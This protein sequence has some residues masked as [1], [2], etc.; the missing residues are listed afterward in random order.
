MS[1]IFCIVWILAGTLLGVPYFYLTGASESFFVHIFLIMPI[2]TVLGAGIFLVERAKHRR[3]L[4]PIF[5]AYVI[6]AIS[7]IIMNGLSLVVKHIVS[8]KFGEIIFEG[9]FVPLWLPPVV[10]LLIALIVNDLLRTHERFENFKDTRDEGK[11]RK[12]ANRT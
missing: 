3:G 7:P 6:W 2:L 11:T 8:E 1:V 12:E 9:R 5:I 4:P 10:L